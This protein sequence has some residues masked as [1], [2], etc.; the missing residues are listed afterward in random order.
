MVR[1][2]FIVI[3]KKVAKKVALKYGLYAGL[4]F[5]LLMFM[6]TANY[7][8]LLFLKIVEAFGFFMGTFFV[9]NDVYNPV[10]D[11]GYTVGDVFAVFFSIIFASFALGTAEPCVKAFTLGFIH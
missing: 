11:D 5:G 7:G 2:N 9:E 8:N 1:L 4:A 10:T 3:L 6:M